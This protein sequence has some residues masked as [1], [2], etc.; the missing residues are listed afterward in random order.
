VR[1]PSTKHQQ[2]RELTVAMCLGRI[3]TRIQK[4][5]VR[6]LAQNSFDF[7]EGPN[8]D[9]TSE[10]D[11]IRNV[12]ATILDQK[13]KQFMLMHRPND[14]AIPHLLKVLGHIDRTLI[15]ELNDESFLRQRAFMQTVLSAAGH[16]LR[17]LSTSSS[18]IVLLRNASWK[19]LDEEALDLLGWGISYSQLAADHVA[20]SRGL[21][22]GKADQRNKIISFEPPDNLDSSFLASQSIAEETLAESFFK[23]FPYE[24]LRGGFQVWLRQFKLTS[25]MDSNMW[26]V[27]Q[28]GRAY[29][30][31][32]SWTEMVVWPELLNET[33]LEGYTLGDFR[34]LYTSLFLV[35]QYCAWAEDAIDSTQG[36]E[37]EGGSIV[38]N[39]SESRIVHWLSEISGVEQSSVH[40]ILCDLIFDT[41][42]FH[43]S[44]ANQPFVRSK[45][46]QI[47]LLARLLPLLEPSRMISGALLKGKKKKVYERVVNTL[48]QSNLDMIESYIKNLG[49]AVFREKKIFANSNF[50]VEPDFLLL[51]KERK[52]LLIIEYKHTLTSIGPSEVVSKVKTLEEGK[53]GIKQVQK[54]LAILKQNTFPLDGH[55]IAP[56]DGYQIYGLLLFRWPM[57][58]PLKTPPDMNI[59]DWI[60]LKEILSW[61]DGISISHLI[62]LINKRPDLPLNPKGWKQDAFEI[63]VDEWTYKHTIF[64]P[65]NY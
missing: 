52:E 65:G 8:V 18:N 6:G 2:L 30:A 41:N 46:R 31:A 3:G 9:M 63:K 7:L 11:I 64:V 55:N 37:N 43:S 15:S 28:D 17:W 54:Y 4:R 56:A 21:L 32:S 33:D 34:R 10:S 24:S 38:F 45:S 58:L 44:L 61:T 42:D 62:D 1:I 51:D 57:V 16:C 19:K 13:H 39:D 26:H 40:N 12:E 14:I 47:F 25:V 49:L 20:W 5:E 36:P 59:I 27:E 48:E 29:E 22:T 60:S 35:A 23:E 50:E 53:G